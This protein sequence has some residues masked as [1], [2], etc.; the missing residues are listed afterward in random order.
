MEFFCRLVIFSLLFI[1]FV[2]HSDS[3][4]CYQCGD[5][6]ATGPCITDTAAM[7]AEYIE[8]NNT[9]HTKVTDG[10]KTKKNDYQ[11]LKNC[12]NTG[13]DRCVIE[14]IEEQGQ[15]H[16]YIR[17][18][19]NSANNY[20]FY[21]PKFLDLDPAR[22]HSS[23]IYDAFSKRVA[24][25]TVCE[26]DFCNGPQ[27]ASGNSCRAQT[28]LVPGYQQLSSINRFATLNDES[29]M[30]I[31]SVVPPEDHNVRMSEMNSSFYYKM[32]NTIQMELT[33]S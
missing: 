13:Y 23:C 1:G 16:A 15:V 25:V 2:Y 20:S 31:K 10:T 28:L 27:I 5:S 32:T 22:N 29:E 24:C 21:D 33:T 6:S 30:K 4:W 17:D 9:D 3:L 7:E 11:Y 19:H 26:T 18:C 12:E 8:Y 14:R